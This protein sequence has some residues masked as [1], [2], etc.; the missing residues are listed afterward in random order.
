MKYTFSLVILPLLL[1]LAPLLATVSSWQLER[2]TDVDITSF[3]R[4]LFRAG[5]LLSVLSVFATASCWIDP[6]PLVS[7]ADG[8]FSIVWLDRAWAVA[9]ITA[10]ISMIVASC[11]KGLPRILLAVSAT[12]TLL[13]TYGS[14]LQNGV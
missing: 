3:R 4:V 12:L 5:L 11:G 6:Y 10:V 1:C 2:R 14:L 9:F 13:L 8:S 7:T